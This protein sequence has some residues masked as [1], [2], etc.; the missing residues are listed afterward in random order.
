LANSALII[1]IAFFEA[2]FKV[3]HTKKFRLSYP[4]PLPTSVAGLFGSMLGI[5]RNEIVS[6]FKNYKFGAAAVTE[7]N[8]SVEQATFIQQGK[9]VRGVADMHL[10]VNPTLYLAANNDNEQEI[11][12]IASRLERGIEHLPFGG[13]NDFFPKDWQ[14]V[15]SMPVEFS[16]KV[17]NYLPSDFVNHVTEDV[18]MEILPVMHKLGKTQEFYFVTGGQLISNRNL[19]VCQVNGKNIALYGLDNFYLVGDWSS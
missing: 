12:E 18:W 6:R 2:H 4:I 17:G 11:N 15:G 8:E 3:H 14:I 10:L 7:H 16:T 19:P 5:D 9:G 13:Q 1:K